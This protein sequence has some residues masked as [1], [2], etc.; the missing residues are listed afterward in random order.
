MKMLISIAAMAW[1]LSLLPKEGRAQQIQL[2]AGPLLKRLQKENAKKQNDQAAV[3]TMDLLNLI[4]ILLQKKEG[5][6]PDDR[7]FIVKYE[8][9]RL[10][11][12]E[13]TVTVSSADIAD[14]P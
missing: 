8:F 5:L 7:R 13:Y 6:Y 11:D 14:N 10:G 4:S 1:N 12:G 9:T 2:T 3:S